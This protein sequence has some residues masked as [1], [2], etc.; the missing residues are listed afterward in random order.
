MLAKVRTL[1]TGKVSVLPVLLAG[2]PTLP[3]RPCSWLASEED[4]V[5]SKGPVGFLKI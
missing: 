4:Q 5:T 3:G 1:E 2:G